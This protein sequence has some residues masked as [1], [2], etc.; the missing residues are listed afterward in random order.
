MQ[1]I[2]LTENDGTK[3][4]VHKPRP[5]PNQYLPEPG[6]LFSPPK[7]AVSSRDPGVV[8]NVHYSH[9]LR[10]SRHSSSRYDGDRRSRSPRDRSPYNDRISQYGDEGRRRSSGETNLNSSAFQANRDSFCRA[11]PRG[12]K[13]L[14]D[15]QATSRG[16]GYVGDFRG[17]GRGGR[18]RNTWGGRDDSPRDRDVRG[19]DDFRREPAAFRDDWSRERV[20]DYRDR[21]DEFPR[22]RTSPQGRA[23]SPQGRDFRDLGVDSERVRRESRDGPLS[24]GSSNSDLPFGQTFRGSGYAPRGGR[25]GR[26]RG[27]YDRRGRPHYEDRPLGDRYARSRSQDG[28]WNR[29]ERDRDPR[30]KPFYRRDSYVR[31]ND[32]DRIHRDK[33][34]IR[35]KPERA[36]VSHDQPAARDISPP[37]LAPPA[38]P[39]GSQIPRPTPTTDLISGIG[40]QPP[41]G[42]RAERPVSAGH[43]GGNE[44]RQP[45]T[46]PRSQGK[47]L[48]RPSSKQ[49]INP[50]LKKCPE[51][52][53]T[54]RPP[55]FAQH[56]RPC[57]FDNRRPENPHEHHGHD[58]NGHERRP[59]S[60]DAKTDDG[61]SCL[62]GDYRDWRGIQSA[63]ASIER[64][65]NGQ[66]PFD[67]GYDAHDRRDLEASP[68]APASSASSHDDSE[69]KTE[70]EVI[71]KESIKPRPHIV[72][73]L[74]ESAGYDVLA[75]REASS[76]SDDEEFG[77]VLE[78][79]LEQVREKLKAFEKPV[80]VPIDAAIRYLAFREELSTRLLN[81][82]LGLLD[83]LGPLVSDEQ[84]PAGPVSQVPS[85]EQA[86]KHIGEPANNETQQEDVEMYDA[87]PTRAAEPVVKDEPRVEPESLSADALMSNDYI[88]KPQELRLTSKISPASEPVQQS[89]SQALPSVRLK[90]T[91]DFIE[92]DVGQL[93]E[94]SV[95]GAD[96]DEPDGPPP[97]AGTE[98]TVD[99]ADISMNGAA[100]EKDGSIRPSE[101]LHTGSAK[102]SDAASSR[103]SSVPPEFITPASAVSHEDSSASHVE[104]GDSVTD[105]DDAELAQLFPIRDKLKTPS[106][107]SLPRY[108]GKEWK[109][110]RRFRRMTAM[111]P[112]TSSYI[113]AQMKEVSDW[114]RAEQ[115]ASRQQ[116]AREY[117]SYL[118]FT[119]SDDPVAVKSRDQFSA[120]AK[121]DF[122]EKTNGKEVSHENTRSRRYASER[123]IEKVLE[124]SKREED[125]RKE[126]QEQAQR[127]RRAGEKEARIPNMYWTEDERRMQAFPDRTGLIEIRWLATDWEV[128]MPIN[129]FSPEEEWAFEK[130][131]LESN[132]YWGKVA[133]ALPDRSYQGCIQYYYLMKRTLSLK[134]KLKKQPKKRKSKQRTKRAV[135]ELGNGD[136]ETDENL[137]TNESGE[138]RRPRRAA[139]P[140]FN[141]ENT[142]DSEL[143]TP[144]ATPGRRR[145]QNNTP[146][147]DSGAEKPEGGRKGRRPRKEKEYKQTKC[148]Q[149]NHQPAD[150][151]G[152]PGTPALAAKTGRSRSNSRV[153]WAASPQLAVERPPPHMPQHDG[154]APGLAAPFIGAMPVDQ[155]DPGQQA[156]PPNMPEAIPPQLRPEPLRHELQ[157]QPSHI[158]SGQPLLDC[159][160][161]TTTTTTTTTR[162]R[163][164]TNASSYWSVSETDNFPRYLRAFGSDWLAIST[165]METKT[166]VMVC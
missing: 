77:S 107:D 35:H 138:R 60:S 156:V 143:G 140:T 45:P 85:Q 14:I 118:R 33:D 81:E 139:A 163:G 134:E 38:P 5:R 17:R 48:P 32:D 164:N 58:H 87:P 144:A 41:T 145:G 43:A 4:W 116:Y 39:F 162:P 46:G 104:E 74:A 69:K 121:E 63:R 75:I 80:E 110:D 16:G 122:K 128:L 61:R 51:S 71:F 131:Y 152:T 2:P 94:Q 135:A 79:E 119:M 105:L 108:K 123:D 18:G 159:P 86:G 133:E 137:E 29:D 34:L 100:T 113:V 157:Q 102:R 26:G 96:V 36:S 109:N 19:R 27:E 67:F 30:H 154:P 24:A 155:H 37:P 99:D 11:P 9:Q 1:G 158:G 150:P 3:P 47:S 25:G 68:K 93:I 90:T 115:E 132:K 88:S 56:Q 6:Y 114:K 129:N 149:Q 31:E 28:R 50:A 8:H 59:R 136:V 98:V 161:S 97:R 117:E 73:V 49:W 76:E 64:E 72:R 13:A 147:G 55:N 127:E 124:M 23:R 130:S 92:K 20:R 70:H 126:R 151:S 7:P 111:D 112:S 89:K 120:N 165:H 66:R 101:V 42:P 21:I 65:H 148:A 91:H 15:A 106:T 125:E 84:I 153:E 146:V 54:S 103:N 82:D 95:E 141:S 52:P 142:A 40:K 160:P 53:H 83:I 62:R 78:A 12:P 22:R 10:A 57:G 166:P 44:C